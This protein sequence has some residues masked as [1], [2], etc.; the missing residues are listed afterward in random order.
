MIPIS[1]TEMVRKIQNTNGFYSVTFTK[2]SDGETRTMN[3]RNE[4]K[5]HLKGGELKFDPKEKKLLMTYS[6]DSKGYRS[7][8][9]EGL[10]SCVIDKIQY[11]VEKGT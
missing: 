8:P 7:I 2:R 10:L 6:I 4:V 11:T 9:V 3:C 5:K 1:R